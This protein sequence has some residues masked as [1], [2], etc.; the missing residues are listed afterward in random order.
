MIS[1]D[2]FSKLRKKILKAGWKVEYT[3]LCGE[4]SHSLYYKGDKTF[5]WTPKTTEEEITKLI[6]DSDE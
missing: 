4:G 5:K 1:R 3:I 2:E 6:E